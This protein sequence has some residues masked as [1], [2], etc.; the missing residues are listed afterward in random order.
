MRYLA[1][2]M[3]IE[4]ILRAKSIILIAFGEKKRA[5]I[6]K[7]L[8]GKVDVHWTITYLLTHPDVTVITDLQA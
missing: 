4:S 6:E 8:E 7:L 2:T 1:F 3:G 5:A